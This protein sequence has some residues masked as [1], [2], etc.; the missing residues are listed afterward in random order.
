MNENNNGKEVI[1][2]MRKHGK[3]DKV[4]KRNTKGKKN[5]KR[6]QT[7][8]RKNSKTRVKVEHIFGFC[9]QSMHVM[10]S[11][12]V[13]F[14]RNATFNTLTNLVYNMNRYEEMVR[15]KMN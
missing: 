14:A 2:I 15:L 8:I 11:R 9:E 3:K 6:Q 5:C 7:N 13:G 10:F 4:T 12:A 1:R